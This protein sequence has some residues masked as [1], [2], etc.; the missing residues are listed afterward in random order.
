[1]T[2][3]AAK[4]LNALLQPLQ[5]G[6]ALEIRNTT[7]KNDWFVKAHFKH[8]D[9]GGL[10]CGGGVVCLFFVYVFMVGK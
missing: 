5:T 2:V 4:A 6:A 1:M 3:Q 8:W 9:F 10:G 7:S